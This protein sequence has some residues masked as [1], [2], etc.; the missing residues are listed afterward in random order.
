M[1][2]VTALGNQQCSSGVKGDGGGSGQ[3]IDIG[4]KLSIG[5]VFD[6]FA[7]NGGLQFRRND[8]GPAGAAAQQR[9]PQHRQQDKPL[10][11]T[12]MPQ[13]DAPAKVHMFC[14]VRTAPTP[15]IPGPRSENVNRTVPR[16]QAPAGEGPTMPN[17]ASPP[18]IPQP[19]PYL[20]R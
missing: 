16:R 5:R 2:V 12:P 8:L 20:I 17:D 14:S 7:I 9:Y 4:F 6:D 11:K 15:Q 10:G 18:R 13:G 19:P 1:A 3:A